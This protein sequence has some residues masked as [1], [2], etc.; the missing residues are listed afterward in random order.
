MRRRL[1]APAFVALVACTSVP[2]AVRAP[3]PEIAP[4]PGERAPTDWAKDTHSPNDAALELVAQRIVDERAR[5]VGTP[6]VDKIVAWMRRYGEPHVRPRVISATGQAPLATDVLDAQI[7]ASRNAHT[8]WA[9]ARGPL[10]HGGETVTALLL[11]AVADMTPLPTRARTGEWLTFDAKLHV[12]ARDAKVIVLGPRGVPRTVPTSFDAATRTA[13]ATFVVDHPGAFVVQLVGDLAEGPRPL[14]EARVFA[15][16][17]PPTN[18]EGLPAVPGEAEGDDLGALV[19]GLRASEL[20]PAL[21]R[22]ARLDAIAREHA[23]RMLD[24]HTIAHDLGEGD[25]RARFVEAGLDA[26]M[27][28]ENVARGSS[29]REAHRAIYASPSH[30][31]NLLRAEYTHL[32]VAQVRGD[33]GVV[34][35]CEVF[36]SGL[37]R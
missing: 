33:D 37:L 17:D 3:D 10:P 29:V 5:G 24:A 12:P 35:V 7:A 20:L 32:G 22:D 19:A 18:D 23:E 14:L 36:A 16:A 31:T 30:R 2:P 13:H 8:R 21:K 25:L 11:D 34:Y 1:L 9:I 4:P 15:D 28:G 6:D 26:R 27:V